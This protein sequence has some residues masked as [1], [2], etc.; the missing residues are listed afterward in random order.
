MDIYLKSCIWE[1]LMMISQA[2]L[3]IILEA[4][5]FYINW[6]PKIVSRIFIV[7]IQLGWA[8]VYQIVIFYI[9][10][11][12]LIGIDLLGL[13]NTWYE[14]TLSFKLKISWNLLKMDMKQHDTSKSMNC[15][16]NM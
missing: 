11:F 7:Y 13:D 4:H 12:L 5:H 3:W 9:R 16:Y 1:Y 2:W 6:V 15:F 10:D 14:E 8:I